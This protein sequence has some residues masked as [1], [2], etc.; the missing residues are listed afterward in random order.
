MQTLEPALVDLALAQCG[1]FSSRQALHL[2]VTAQDLSELVRVGA[3]ERVR[4]GAY[5]L[6]SALEAGTPEQSYAVRVRS[7]LLSRPPLTWA[8]HHA[9]LALE[10]LPL[11]GVDLN[12][13]DLSTKVSRTFRRSGVVTHPLPPDE[14]C[15]LVGGARSVSMALALVRTTTASGL[16]AGVVALD[17]ALH[18][19]AVTVEQLN[20][21]VARDRLND[22]AVRRVRTALGLVDERC[23]SPGESLT[24]MVMHSLGIPLRSQVEIRDVRG[25]IGRVDFVVDTWIV[26]EFDGLQKYGSSDGRAALAREKVREDRLRSAGYEVIRITWGDLDAPDRI[27]RWVREA[28]G[29]V[30]LRGR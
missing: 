26:V 16:K 17:A 13:I 30:A 29:R 8:S 12:R 23:E 28:R 20:A 15:V 25:F 21:A 2:G 22:R 6:P 1:A 7:V 10:A 4:Q 9:A 14:P 24:R 19:G 18:R 3:I 27:A 5:A 11:V